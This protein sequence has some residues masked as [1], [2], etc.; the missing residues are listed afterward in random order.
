MLNVRR[1]IF[2]GTFL[3]ITIVAAGW[4]IG[5][6]SGGYRQFLQHAQSIT[7]AQWAMLIAATVAFYLLDYA[8]LYTLFALLGFRIPLATG[9]QVTCVSYF[10]SSLT[11]TA[12]LNIPAMM[13]MLHQRGIPASQTAAVAVVKTLYMTLWVCLFGFGTFLTDYRVPLPATIE[14]HIVLLTAPA[15]ALIVAFFCIV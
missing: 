4:A 13:L 2:W 7:L 14:D 8:R 9:L 15:V 11:P 1:V 3:G 12:E 5:H 10:V 6:Y